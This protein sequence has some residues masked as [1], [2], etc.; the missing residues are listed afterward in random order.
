MGITETEESNGRGELRGNF[1]LLT[2]TVLTKG[3]MLAKNRDSVRKGTFKMTYS[4][5]LPHV[6]KKYMAEL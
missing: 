2:Q 5:T 3:I 6:T 1:D 4:Q